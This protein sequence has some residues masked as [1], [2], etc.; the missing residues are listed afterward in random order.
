MS[1][2]VVPLG[3]GWLRA[4]AEETGSLP[5]TPLMWGIAAKTLSTLCS[6]PG[7]RQGP[8]P[9]CSPATLSSCS[10]CQ[11]LL[12]QLCVQCLPSPR[13]P[14]S[15]PSLSTLDH[16]PLHHSH[17]VMGPSKNERLLKLKYL[18]QTSRCNRCK[19][20]RLGDTRHPTLRIQ[21]D[22]HEAGSRPS[23]RSLLSR[24]GSGG[25]HLLGA[26]CGNM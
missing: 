22:S 8:R 16:V 11:A 24:E 15:P 17:T 3:N 6:G 7:L 14:G 4:G 2:V 9:V 19:A 23:E 21:G 26:R 18:T 1:I 12:A 10:L 20:A 25:E 13:P 5:V